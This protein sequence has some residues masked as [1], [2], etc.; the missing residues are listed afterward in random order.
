MKKG[1]YLNCEWNEYDSGNNADRITL[2]KKV[3]SKQLN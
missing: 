2:I 3:V 1:N